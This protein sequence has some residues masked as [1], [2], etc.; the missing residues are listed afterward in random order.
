MGLTKGP[1]GKR[2]RSRPSESN[3]IRP[4]SPKKAYTLLPS[5]TGVGEAGPLARCI[6]SDRGRGTSFFHSKSPLDRS[7]Q[8]THSRF[9]SRDDRKMRFRVRTGEDWPG[10]VEARQTRFRWGPNRTGKGD[11]STTPVLFLPRNWDHS[12][13]A[14]RGTRCPRHRSNATQTAR[15]KARPR[16]PPNRLPA[17]TERPLHPKPASLS[18]PVTN[19]N[20]KK[21]FILTLTLTSLRLAP[22]DWT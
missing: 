3:E 12:A 4:K 14:T 16:R 9:P 22:N 13:A 11:V 6:T 7:R 2:Q 21:S 5:V 20:P 17:K 18:S 15:L 10:P 1:R 8:I 19:L